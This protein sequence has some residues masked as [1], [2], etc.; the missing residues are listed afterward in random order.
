M[1]VERFS[2]ALPRKKYQSTTKLGSTE[3]YW[4]LRTRARFSGPQS[5]AEEVAPKQGIW[6]GFMHQILVGS[7]LGG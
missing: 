1:D 7:L 4:G 5:G 2:Q 6:R 3:L